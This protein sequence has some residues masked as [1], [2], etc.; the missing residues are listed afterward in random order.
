MIGPLV[1]VQGPCG[2]SG[3]SACIIAF[4]WCARVAEW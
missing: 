2:I 1:M 3:P 4:D